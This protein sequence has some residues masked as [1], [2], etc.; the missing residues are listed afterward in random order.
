MSNFKIVFG[1]LIICVCVYTGYKL[2]QKYSKRK[3]F[4]FSLKDFNRKMISEVSFSKI[5]LL[6]IIDETDY[7]N[8]FSIY[9]KGFKNY[10]LNGEKIDR[11]YLWFLTED[12]LREIDYYF[13]NLGKTDKETLIV[14]LKKSD[15]KFLDYFEKSEIE[16]K[17]YGGLYVKM[18]FLCGIMIFVIII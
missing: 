8:E 4:F 3:N 7:K 17:K 11:K 1:V 13:S 16:Y 12:E 6:K 15:E 2:T 9:L 10:L 5:N 18:G 14:Y